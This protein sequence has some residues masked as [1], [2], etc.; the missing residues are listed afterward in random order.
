MSES[1]ESSQSSVHS[2]NARRPTRRA[3]EAARQKVAKLTDDDNDSQAKSQPKVPQSGKQ[4]ELPSRPRARIVQPIEE[5]EENEENVAGES[6][7]NLHQIFI[8]AQHSVHSHEKL[9]ERFK[10][11]LQKARFPSFFTIIEKIIIFSITFC[12]RLDPS[13]FGQKW[14]ICCGKFYSFL[15]ESLMQTA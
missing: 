13:S 2:E 9:A 11:L 3:K 15:S 6:N 4:K 5:L 12:F 14:S 1:T 8:D 10:T 7:G